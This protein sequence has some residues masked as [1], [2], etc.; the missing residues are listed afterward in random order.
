MTP[1]HPTR[2]R[3]LKFDGDDGEVLTVEVASY[4]DAWIE[5]IRRAPYNK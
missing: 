2:M 4:T 3:G 1:S 5:I